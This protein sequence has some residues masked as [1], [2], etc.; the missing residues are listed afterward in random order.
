MR[1]IYNGE[2][3]DRPHVIQIFFFCVMCGLILYLPVCGT[4]LAWRR[5]DLAREICM[6]IVAI[7]FL[8]LNVILI[9]R[10]FI[11]LTINKEK[12]IVKRPLLR[13]SPFKKDKA[14]VEFSINDIVEINIVLPPLRR[15]T[16][17]WR[18]ISHD[19]KE[20][21]KIRFEPEFI[22]STVDLDDYFTKNN[23][24]IRVT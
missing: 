24:P 23:I 19:G 5:G 2:I 20:L 11:F 10:E 13:F 4:F 12:I 6:P 18:F 14:M 22:F 9:G 1:G 7:L 3:K 8:W 15:P 16:R 21:L 17:T